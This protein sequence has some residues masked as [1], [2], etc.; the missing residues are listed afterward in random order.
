[1]ELATHS[2]TISNPKMSE[3]DFERL[4]RTSPLRPRVEAKLLGV[5]R[6][7]RKDPNWI[8]TGVLSGGRLGTCLRNMSEH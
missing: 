3:V 8:P 1:M 4:F 5:A 7:M 6:R 2:M